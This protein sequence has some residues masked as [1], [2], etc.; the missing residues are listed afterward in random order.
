MT[1][2]RRETDSLGVVAARQDSPGWET[3]PGFFQ[4]CWPDWRLHWYRVSGVADRKGDWM[5]YVFPRH[6]QNRQTLP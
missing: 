1:N 3:A 4:S 6:C 2:M 5:F